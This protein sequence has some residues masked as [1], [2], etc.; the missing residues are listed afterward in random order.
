MKKKKYIITICI[1]IICIFTTSGCGEEKYTKE[2]AMVKKTYDSI[3]DNLLDP[4]SII[5][6]DCYGWSAKSEEQYDKQWEENEGKSSDEEIEL[7]DDMYSVYFY[8]GARNKL[9]GI[10]DEEYIYMYDLN[11]NLLDYSSESDYEDWSSDFSYAS[12]HHDLMGQFLNP[13]YWKVAG[14]ESADDYNEL[15]KSDDFEKI[16]YEKILAN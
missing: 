4:D 7:P 15:V 11:G 8:V 13:T 1:T 6:Y 9:G 12:T 3:K 10:S 5:V 14:W 16:N 2:Q